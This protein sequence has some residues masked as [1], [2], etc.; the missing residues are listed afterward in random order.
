M[1]V[2]QLPLS[3]YLFCWKI[4][5]GVEV[6][7][8]MF[9]SAHYQLNATE[10]PRNISFLKKKCDESQTSG[11][12]KDFFITKAL[13]AHLYVKSASSDVYISNVEGLSYC[14]FNNLSHQK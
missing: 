14:H 6:H 3:I 8:T 9:P 10:I 2:K 5:M 13:I 7:K 11:K 4:I 12:Q 1:E